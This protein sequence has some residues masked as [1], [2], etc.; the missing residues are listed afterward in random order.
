MTILSRSNNFCC[1][2]S[3]AIGAR[4]SLKTC[5]TMA[6]T[7]TMR[8]NSSSS[9]CP[10]VVTAA[11]MAVA[12]LLL[13][14]CPSCSALQPAAAKKAVPGTR[15]EVVASFEAWVESVGRKHAAYASAAESAGSDVQE[16][17]SKVG[18]WVIVVDQSGAGNYKTVTEAVN[19]VPL[20][21]KSP[22]TIKVNAGTYVS[23]SPSNLLVTN[24]PWPDPGFFFF[25]SFFYK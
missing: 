16:L 9:S 15:A 19:A 22:V 5:P 17:A 11:V 25:F 20:H 2:A 23:V 4:S 6:G 14:S 3:R 8:W 12:L 24:P 21:N 7:T 18:E 1:C 13:S 10:P